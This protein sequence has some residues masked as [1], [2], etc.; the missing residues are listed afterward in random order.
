MDPDHAHAGEP[1]RVID[2]EPAPFGQHRAVGGV[3]RDREGLGDT[4]DRQVSDHQRFQCPPQRPPGELRAR[5]G[6]TAQ[7][8]TPHVSAPTASVATN[9]HQQRGG[10]PPRRVRERGDGSRC[11]W[12]RPR[13]RT[14]D[15]TRRALPRD[16]PR[17]RDRTQDAARRQQGQARQGR[18]TWSGQDK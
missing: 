1:G 5:L 7:V 11:P 15:T 6:R 17:P 16:R 14:D 18:R 2:E 13:I 4:G 3:P 9:R 8:L 10:A 12:A